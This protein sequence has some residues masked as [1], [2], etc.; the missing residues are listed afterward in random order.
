MKKFA[1]VLGGGAAKGFAHIGVIKVLEQYNLKPD[2]IVGTSMGAIIGGAYAKGMES[3]KMEEFAKSIN[4]NKVLDV[5]LF[6]MVKEGFIVKGKKLEKIARGLLGSAT[7]ENL[8]IPFVAVATELSTGKQI[9]LDKGRVWKNVLASSAI[10]A[11]FPAIKIDDKILCDGGLKNNVP[12]TLARKIMK[13]AV[14]LSIDVIGD[15]EKQV[16]TGGVK[17]INQILNMGTLLMSQNAK[18][19]KSASDVY[20][21]ITQPDINQMGFNKDAIVKSISNGEKA[22]RRNIK[23]LIELLQN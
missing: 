12:A 7:H 8:K 14:I 18:Q 3:E 15:Y 22:M 19:D 10:P 16:E 11:V 1:L 21:K 5:S 17:V 13:D 9:N 4:S 23:K 20:I 6:N 2:L